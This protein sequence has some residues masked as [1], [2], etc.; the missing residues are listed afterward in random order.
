[1]AKAKVCRLEGPIVLIYRYAPV[2]PPWDTSTTVTFIRTAYPSE[3]L[4]GGR[5]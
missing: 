4:M 5:G 1:M 3:L 2:N